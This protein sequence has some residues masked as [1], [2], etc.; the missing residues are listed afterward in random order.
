MGN[1]LKKYELKAALANCKQ[2]GDSVNTYYNRLRKIWDELQHH[3][4]LQTSKVTTL[5]IKKREE[6]QVYQFLTRLNNSIYGIGRSSIIQEESLPKV[7]NVLAK[8]YKEGQ[9][10]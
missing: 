7:K 9:Y 8:I 4:Q 1:G 2:V 10:R 5:I 3:M 6:E